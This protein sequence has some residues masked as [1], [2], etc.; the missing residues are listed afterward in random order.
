M[1]LVLEQ[2]FVDADKYFTNNG[3][4]GGDTNESNSTGLGKDELREKISIAVD[5]IF[6]SFDKDETGKLTFMEYVQASMS[7]PEL[8]DFMKG[9]DFENVDIVDLV[10]ARKAGRQETASAK[11][12]AEGMPRNSETLISKFELAFQIR[13]LTENDSKSRKEEVSKSTEFTRRPP[14]MWV[15]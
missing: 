9:V 6:K 7:L 13:G 5:S 2:I 1:K 11:H 10:E 8:T 14:S 12:A 3:V 4:S 15:W